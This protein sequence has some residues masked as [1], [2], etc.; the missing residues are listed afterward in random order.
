MP[1]APEWRGR[2]NE[3]APRPA[4]F[5]MAVAL[6]EIGPTVERVIDTCRSHLPDGADGVEVGDCIALA[7]T[8]VLNNCVEHAYQGSGRGRVIIET[9]LPPGAVILH[10]SDRG[11]PPPLSLV[12]AAPLP[13]PEDM[14]ESGWGWA[15]I[16]RLSD[17]VDYARRDGWNRLTLERR[18]WRY[19]DAASAW[20]RRT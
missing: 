17:R 4:R 1:V 10:V 15:L 19:Y 6:A 7:L 12:R 16:H 8:E 3:P 20:T 18:F 5:E 13:D 14:P 9:E 2:M 11:R